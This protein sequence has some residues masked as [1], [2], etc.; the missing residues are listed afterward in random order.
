MQGKIISHNKLR[1]LGR[2]LTCL[3]RDILQL[4][5]P[6]LPIQ[7][8]QEEVCL[9]VKEY[10]ANNSWHEILSG[11]TIDKEYA[12]IFNNP[13]EDR[14][15]MLLVLWP[16]NNV[17]CIHN[18]NTWACIGTIAGKEESQEWIIDHSDINRSNTVLRKGKCITLNAGETV[19]L[20][21]H[22]IHHVNNLN[23]QNQITASLHIYGKDLRQS[24]REIFDRN[25]QSR[26]PHPNDEFC[27]ISDL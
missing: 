2:I 20:D 12:I 10:I 22:C 6:Q 8:K 18:H 21:S 14:C 11:I 17:S 15:M 26:S 4:A 3:K 23:Q 1:L 16:G 7:P 24:H 25:K 5:I 27:H 9:L 13:E 19:W